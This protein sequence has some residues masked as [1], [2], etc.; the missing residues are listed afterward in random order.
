MFLLK[1]IG[2]FCYF[3]VNWNKELTSTSKIAV[4]VPA[5]RAGER[6]PIP[7]E[8][9]ETDETNPSVSYFMVKMANGIA[10]GRVLSPTTTTTA[11]VE[12]EVSHQYGDLS[13]EI[14]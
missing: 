6:S 9:G 7:I 2:Y 8:I 3:F 11:A 5:P 1:E 4:A 12:V 10:R 13:H 14:P